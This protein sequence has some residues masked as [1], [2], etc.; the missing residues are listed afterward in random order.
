M[1]GRSRAAQ[2][3]LPPPVIRIVDATL[4]QGRLPLE[5]SSFLAKLRHVGPFRSKQKSFAAALCLRAQPEP[6]RASRVRH[7]AKPLPE[8][9]GRRC[10]QRQSL[11]SYKPSAI[12]HSFVEP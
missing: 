1:T 6:V 11:E 8:S 12:S 7:A 9:Q 2:R 5:V 10:R 4:D 3:G